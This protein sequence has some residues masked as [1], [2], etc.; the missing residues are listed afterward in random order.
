MS[1]YPEGSYEK[2]MYDF[3][4]RMRLMLCAGYG[5]GHELHRF[6]DILWAR[7]EVFVRLTPA[8]I[9]EIMTREAPLFHR[10]ATGQMTIEDARKEEKA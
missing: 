5:E 1:Y 10:V 2:E 9:A 8:E 6:A 4:E 3:S 7:N